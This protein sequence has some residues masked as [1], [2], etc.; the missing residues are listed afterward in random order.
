MK[1]KNKNPIWTW[2]FEP[3]SIAVIAG[4]TPDSFDIK[5]YDDRL[6]KIPYDEKTNLVC[7]TVETLN[8]RRSY[9][10]ATEYRKRNVPVL[11]GGFHPTLFPEEAINYTDSV[12]IGEAEGVWEKILNDIKNKKLKKF[13]ISQHSYIATPNRKIYQGHSYI[14]ITLME[15]AR[16]CGYKCEFCSIQK[17]YRRYTPRDIKDVVS[18]IKESKNKFFMFVDDCFTFDLKRT[19]KLLLEIK[20]LKIKWI[21]QA[22]IWFAQDDDLLKL[23]KDSGCIG[24]LIGIESLNRKNLL[25]MRKGFVMSPSKI[26]LLLEKIMQE[27][28]AIYASFIYGYDEDDYKSLKEILL[29]ALKKKFFLAG[30]YPLLPFPGTD[31]YKRLLN[32][33]RLLKKEWWLDPDYK[34][35][36]IVFKPNKISTQE[37]YEIAN[38]AK[39]KFYSPIGIL[40]RVMK[41]P[42][43]ASPLNFILYFLTNIL[44]RYEIVS[45]LGK[46]L[47][48]L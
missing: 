44:A 21:T 14:P 11:M 15:T 47:G 9:Q 10:I 43:F 35:G 27:G 5:F 12:V 24:L 7:L 48:Q 8:A 22:G 34:Y 39:M 1:L 18:E 4:I 3:L 20:P 37:L 46:G 17:F 19:E 33:N 31:L 36:D 25:K 42:V 2:N 40:K 28:I 38:F 6:E 32:E 41:K 29:Y 45:K 23:F 30:F 13:Y 26:D 16:G